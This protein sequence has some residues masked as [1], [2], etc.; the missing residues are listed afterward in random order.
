MCFNENMLVLTYNEFGPNFLSE[1]YTFTIVT[2]KTFYLF[3][4]F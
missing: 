1:M 4:Q 3:S 2:Q